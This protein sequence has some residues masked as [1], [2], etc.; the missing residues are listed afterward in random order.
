MSEAIREVS[1]DPGESPAPQPRSQFSRGFWLV[2]VA[3]FALNI[4]SNLFVLFPLYLVKLGADA[5]MI[6]AVV[7]TFSLAALAVRPGLGVLLDRVG[8]Q[9]TAMWLMALDVGVI[10]LYMAVHGLGWS[11]FAVRVL[12]G[13]VE[14][15]ARVA[16][17]AM[18]YEFMPVEG[19]GQ[20]MAIFSLCGMGS[21]GVGP[22]LGEWVIGRWGF[23]AFFATAMALTFGSAIA[24]ARIPDDRAMRPSE[25][26]L[27]ASGGPGFRAL[28]S[29]PALMPLW[30]AT[31]L[32][33]L[34]ISPRLS[35]VAPFAQQKGV[36]E[37]AW[38]FVLYSVPALVVRIFG[39]R[40]MDRI[41]LERMVAPSL[42]VLA[43]GMALIAATGRFHLLYAAALIGGLGHGY[44]YPAL[45]ALVI[46]R[47]HPSAAARSSSIYSSLY[48]IG[49]M[50]GPYAF[51]I[52]ASL[53]GYG[54]MFVAAGVMSLVGAVYFTLAEP[55]ARGL[56]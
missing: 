40:L 19:A 55:D 1:I 21:A 33:S 26:S 11:I 31:V 50:A 24:T 23:R 17:F 6:G 18:V 39:A 42:S 54:P 15:T 29:D 49:A 48:D 53:A 45:T 51:G 25:P 9:R 20:A 47:T 14:G 32:F 35:F 5:K 8:R 52:F 37:V 2:F 30:I 44:L 27:R 38:Y 34:S 46:R 13:I 12:H 36:N 43:F 56:A 3:T 28:I 22:I 16:L 10:A 4:S 41:G 7:G